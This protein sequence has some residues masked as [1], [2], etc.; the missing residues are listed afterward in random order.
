[1]ACEATGSI[2]ATRAVQS[3][4]V[5][6]QIK[7]LELSC[8]RFELHRSLGR[9]NQLS[10]RASSAYQSRNHMYGFTAMTSSAVYVY[11]P[12][13]TVDGTF[14]AKAAHYFLNKIIGSHGSKLATV[15]MSAS[16]FCVGGQS[17]SQG[18]G[19]KGNITQTHIKREL[20]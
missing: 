13:S 8:R 1:M 6:F 11:G 3:E 7:R 9:L 19:Q 20:I 16:G 15:T 2:Q 17:K 12:T 14:R 5:N 4:L 10:L 18:T